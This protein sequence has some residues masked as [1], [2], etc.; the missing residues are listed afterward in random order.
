M[1]ALRILHVTES[2]GGGVSDAVRSYARATPQYEH[3]LLY[4]LREKAPF[5][6]SV[7]DA[8][9]SSK[10]LGYGHMRRIQHIRQQVTK[11]KIDIVHVHSSLGG[12][13]GRLAAI[14][15]SV[16]IVYTPHCFAFERRDISRTMR[17]LFYLAELVLARAATDAFAACSD[18]ERKL[19]NRLAPTK[20]AV[21]VPNV[22][23]LAL[24]DESNEEIQETFVIAGAG[25]AAAQKD[26]SAF[27]RIVAPFSDDTA[28]SAVWL[29]GGEPDLEQ[30]LRRSHVQVTG[31]LSKAEL[32]KKLG[33]VSLYLHTAKW[34][35][36]PIG[37]L[38]A[39]AENVPSLVVRQPYTMGLPEEMIVDDETH[40]IQRI[41]QLAIDP[42][43]RE[44][45]QNVAKDAFR[46]NTLQL[47]SRRLRETYEAA[48]SGRQM[49]NSATTY[50]PNEWSA[51]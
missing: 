51:P 50:P 2:F 29:G 12:L 30:E 10:P 48:M 47:Q 18:R 25:R 43:A 8:F 42:D 37:L 3:H 39:V 36:F 31:W 15:S 7:L 19:A 26:P 20:P 45:L 49:S 5:E 34:E 1:S 21:V 13:Y 24:R 23:Q 9:A 44:T 17:G 41:R 14:T 38:E 22:S 27:A 32:T 6:P 11:S 46:K 33:G 35:G 40:A 16:C 4:S 28:Y